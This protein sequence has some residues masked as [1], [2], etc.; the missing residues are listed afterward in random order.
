MEH[1]IL[2]SEPDAVVTEARKWVG[3]WEHKSPAFL[4]LPT[5]NAGKGGYTAFGEILRQK[6]GKGLQRRPWCAVFVHA[7]FVNA[8]GEY[9]ARRLLGRPHAGTRKL[10]RRLRRKGLYADKQHHKPVP[11]DIIFL[12]NDCVHID[13]VGIVADADHLYVT[14]IEGNTYDR[15]GP[16]KIGEGGAVALRSRTVFDAKIIGYGATGRMVQYADL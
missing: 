16:F 12:A 2:S 15:N 3:Y 10:A 4:G 7:V 13:H 14:S 1:F 9:N 8:L 6:C 11:G 5:Q